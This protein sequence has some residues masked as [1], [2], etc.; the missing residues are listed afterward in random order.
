MGW[1]CQ[2]WLRRLHYWLYCTDPNC[3]QLASTYCCVGRPV[4]CCCAPE[5][6]CSII[7]VQ[8]LQPQKIALNGTVTML[9]SEAQN[10]S[11]SVSHLRA[12]ASLRRYVSL[13]YPAFRVTKSDVSQRHLDRLSGRAESPIISTLSYTCAKQNHSY[14]PPPRPSPPRCRLVGGGLNQCCDDTSSLQSASIHINRLISSLKIPAHLQLVI[15]RA[16]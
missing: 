15:Q 9:T 7:H 13:V 3:A 4:A 5:R 2:C 12:P 14:L 10:A 8:P 16:V 6:A 11:M 1:A